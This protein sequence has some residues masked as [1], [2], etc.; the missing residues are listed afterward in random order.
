MNIRFDQGKICI[1][2]G[3]SDFADAFAEATY[4]NFL[5]MAS[6]AVSP[7]KLFLNGQLK[8]KGNLAKGYEFR[9]TLSPTKE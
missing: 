1:S 8:F 6:G 5:D 9:R 7:D 4:D 2:K 3:Y